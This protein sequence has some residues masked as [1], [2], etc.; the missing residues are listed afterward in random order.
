MNRL[1]APAILSMSKKLD[2]VRSKLVSL[3]E[4]ARY[5][6]LMDLTRRY[7]EMIDIIDMPEEKRL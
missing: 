4:I 5:D 7:Q 3:Q 6:N 2:I 1:Y